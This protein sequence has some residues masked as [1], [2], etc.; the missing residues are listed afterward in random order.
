LSGLDL[1]SFNAYR[2]FGFILLPEK[3]MLLY[4]PG[5]DMVLGGLGYIGG[6]VP[7]ARPARGPSAAARQGLFIISGGGGGILT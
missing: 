1:I 3:S 6:R 2:Y 7:A 5:V 4:P